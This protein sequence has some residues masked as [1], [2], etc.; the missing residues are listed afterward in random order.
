MVYEWLQMVSYVSFWH[1][2]QFGWIDAVM[3]SERLYT[4]VK[5]CSCCW[6]ISMGRFLNPQL[7]LYKIFL[8]IFLLGA[9]HINM[10]K[11]TLI[12]PCLN[13]LYTKN[14]IFPSFNPFSEYF[15][16][17]FVIHFSDLMCSLR[18]SIA[19]EKC[20]NDERI[21]SQFYAIVVRYSDLNALCSIWSVFI[22][23]TYVDLQTIVLMLYTSSLH[24]IYWGLS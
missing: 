20:C 17:L 8:G 16:D 15:W 22:L 10:Y 2:V 12:H 11:R 14:S 21:K 4:S 23:L 13:C 9:L 24:V 1:C 5:L 6:G 3:C 19:V 7:G 18:N